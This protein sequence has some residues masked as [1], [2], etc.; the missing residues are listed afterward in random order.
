MLAKTLFNIPFYLLLNVQNCAAFTA[1]IVTRGCLFDFMVKIAA[2]R[3]FKK[4]CK[5]FIKKITARISEL[6]IE[7]NGIQKKF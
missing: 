4:D 7:F 6:V 1:C 2:V 5:N 3:S